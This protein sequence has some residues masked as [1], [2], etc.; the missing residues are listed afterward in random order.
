MTLTWRLQ[1]CS[2]GLLAVAIVLALAAAVSAQETE[3]QMLSGTGFGDEVDWEFTVTGGRRAGERATI[4]VP[5]QWEQHG[6]GV[7]NYGHDDDKSREQGRYRHR[8]EVPAAWRGKIVDLVFEGVMTDAEVRLNG[9]SAGPTHRGAFTRFRYD[10]TDLVRAGD[11]NELEVTVA[12]HSADASVN[13]A[14]GI[15]ARTGSFAL[16]RPATQPRPD[17][18]GDYRNV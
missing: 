7:Y 18:G 6:F 2:A 3:R 17:V 8:F 11:E 10:V 1:D 12:K 9:E 15:P 5:S 14:E 13:R 16:A 4:P